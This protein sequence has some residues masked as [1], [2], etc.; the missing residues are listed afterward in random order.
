[1]RLSVIL[2]I[3]LLALAVVAKFLPTQ[4]HY[5][6]PNRLEMDV[7]LSRVEVTPQGDVEL[8]WIKIYR[9]DNSSDFVKYCAPGYVG[10]VEPQYSMTPGVVASAWAPDGRPLEYVY[11]R[12][13]AV[14]EIPG[15]VT[16]A[17]HIKWNEWYLFGATLRQLRAYEAYLNDSYISYGLNVAVK[18]GNGTMLTCLQ[19]IG[20]GLLN[21]TC[22]GYSAA[23][24]IVARVSW[25]VDYTGS[26]RLCVYWT[27]FWQPWWYRWGGYRFTVDIKNPVLEYK[28]CVPRAAPPRN[29][30]AVAG[31]NAVYFYVDGQLFYTLNT[32]PIGG[33]E[34]WLYTGPYFVAYGGGPTTA[35]AYVAINIL[36]GRA[37]A[38]LGRLWLFIGNETLAAPRYALNMEWGSG[39]LEAG[40]AFDGL[41]ASVG[42]GSTRAPSV[43]VNGPVNVTLHG[44]PAVVQRGTY[45]TCDAG[46]AVARGDAE[47]LGRG[48]IVRGPAEL[49]CTHYSVLV[50][51]YNSTVR[52]VGERGRTLAYAPG[53]VLLPN[54]TLLRARP[55]TVSFDRPGRVYAVNY[56]VYYRLFVETPLGVNETW[57]ERGSLFRYGGADVVLGNGTRVVV[58]P[59]AVA[60]A[61]PA[62]VRPNYTVY[63]LVRVASPQGVG[64]EWIPRGSVYRPAAPDPWLPGNGTKFEGLLVNGT[65]AGAYVVDRP[66]ALYLSYRGKY[67]WIAVTTPFNKTEGWLRPGEAVRLPPVVDFGNGTRLVDPQPAEVVADGP[68]DV[69]VSYRRQYWVE[70]HGVAEWRGWAYEGAAIRLNETV[71]NG[72]RYSP[73]VP[74]V[75]VRGP[76]NKTVRYAASYY[77]EFRDALGLPDPSAEVSLCGRIFGA[78]LAGRVYAYAETVTPCQL[79]VRRWPLSPYTLAAIA[80]AATAFLLK[81]K[82]A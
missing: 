67:Y 41:S 11:K 43:A 60:V 36:D 59:A 58:E 68:R 74:Y 39:R 18:L 57:A 2:G 25:R 48:Y 70:V 82:K 72:V 77:A 22:P 78:D 69:A 45:F 29:I 28:G 14:F 56:T 50:R 5:Y 23:K 13:V 79:E 8:Y 75:E 6:L 71:I 17:T 47:P 51:E 10:C 61:G 24:V 35:S 38:H 42:P 1:M 52:L 20:E 66:L 64:E 81:R 49:Y 27:T 33:E 3:A 26:K 80:A 7:D 32:A 15:N 21:A 9:V 65:P 31:R 73:E 62:R 16:P 53:D 76:V 44:E 54:G 37:A 12:A 19:K 34:P 46:E 63:Y 55:I 4:Y 40:V 30:T